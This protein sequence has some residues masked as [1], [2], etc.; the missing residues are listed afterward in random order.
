MERALFWAAALMLN[1]KAICPVSVNVLTPMPTGNVMSAAPV[2]MDYRRSKR[3]GGYDTDIDGVFDRCDGGRR[4]RLPSGDANRL[5][6]GRLGE[7]GSE[8]DRTRY[9]LSIEVEM[10]V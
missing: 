7:G 5:W 6:A 3:W 2:D 1:V 8:G 9:S 4:R 10:K